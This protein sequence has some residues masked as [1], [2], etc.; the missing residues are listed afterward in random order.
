MSKFLKVIVIVLCVL[1][2]I[3]NIDKKEKDDKYKIY[4]DDGYPLYQDEDFDINSRNNSEITNK[5]ASLLT[6]YEVKISNQDDDMKTK[7][8]EYNNY[9]LAI[10]VHSEY[11]DYDHYDAYVNRDN[12]D[13]EIFNSLTDFEGNYYYDLTLND[14]NTYRQRVIS[15]DED[16]DE[17]LGFLANCKTKCIWLNIYHTDNVSDDRIEKI[18]NC[19]INFEKSENNEG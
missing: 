9:D 17:T 13:I 1:S 15:V 8:K 5:I 16:Y 4:L 3:L 18:V 11:S 19:I 7:S 14:D 10:S 12:K 2:I 6:D